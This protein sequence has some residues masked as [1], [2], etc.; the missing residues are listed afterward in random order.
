MANICLMTIKLYSVEKSSTV[1]GK[2]HMN[3][4]WIQQGTCKFSEKKKANYT[5]KVIFGL[6]NIPF[7]YPKQLHGKFNST[8]FSGRN[9]HWNQKRIFY[10]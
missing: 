4:A 7:F 9:I 3:S 10:I 5:D 6:T 2:R 8:V 1:A